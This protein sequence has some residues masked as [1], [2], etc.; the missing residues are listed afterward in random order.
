MKQALEIPMLQAPPS[1]HDLAFL[2]TAAVHVDTFSRLSAQ[3]NGAL[4]VRHV[5]A[6]QLLH[7]ARQH[8][9]TDHLVRQVQAAMAEAASSGAR[10][11]VCT[12][13]TIGGIAEAAT[14]P[15]RAMRID[16][17][18]ADAAVRSGKRILVI[19]AL[20]STLAPTLALL[21]DS[22][23]RAGLKPRI[24]Q[25]L[26]E[27]AWARFEAGEREAYLAAVTDAIRT[28]AGGADVVVLA[29]ASMA[30]AADRCGDLGIPVLSSPLPGV[31]AAVASCLPAAMPHGILR[32]LE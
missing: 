7:D 6:E 17:A 22:A 18:M 12:C 10:V 9:V 8:G 15:F 21:Q 32:P 1:S 13:S 19:A 20:E 3:V 31:E 23:R 30:P 24:T 25:A 27:G 29:Q 11:V 2:H 28:H 16:R 26:A 14:G 4:R 5:V